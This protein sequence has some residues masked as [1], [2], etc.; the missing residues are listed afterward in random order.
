M[1]L[2]LIKGLIKQLVININQLKV[3]LYLP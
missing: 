3:N 2:E 1:Y